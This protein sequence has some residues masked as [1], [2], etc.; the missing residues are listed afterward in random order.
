M[1]KQQGNIRLLLNN[2]FAT[3]DV[4]RNISSFSTNAPAMLK[5]ISEFVFLILNTSLENRFYL[6]LFRISNIP[7]F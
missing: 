2:L 4:R 1:N 3:K 5:K 6:K 7:S